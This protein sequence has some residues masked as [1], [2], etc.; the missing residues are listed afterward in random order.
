MRSQFHRILSTIKI[1]LS[2]D[3]LYL[4]YEKYQDPDTGLIKYLSFV[5]EVDFP[6]WDPSEVRLTPRTPLPI[7]TYSS[8][9]VSRGVIKKLQEKIKD[10]NLN[11]Y[12]LFTKYDVLRSGNVSRKQL[13][14]VIEKFGI[15][16]TPVEANAI[17]N[18]YSLYT[19]FGR[20]NWKLFIDDIEGND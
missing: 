19:D 3:D 17:T 20:C 14:D 6:K 9:S 11:I 4:L 10:S 16:L 15:T 2:Q 7:D 8:S 5:D 18:R 12:D 1:N 13:I